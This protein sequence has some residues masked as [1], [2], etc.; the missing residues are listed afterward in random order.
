MIAWLFSGQKFAT[1]LALHPE[2]QADKYLMVEEIA[3]TV[4][5]LGADEVILTTEA[6]MAFVEPEYDGPR[7]GL[8]DDRQEALLTHALSRDG[9]RQM[10]RSM[11]TRQGDE[12]QLGEPT[13]ADGIQPIFQ[14][15][16]DAWAEWHAGSSDSG[17]AT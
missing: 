12:V 1:Q 13:T 9:R 10:W 5:E 6:W 15:V 16:F 3:R 4:N 8:R 7:A 2:K 14:P 17:A 11:V